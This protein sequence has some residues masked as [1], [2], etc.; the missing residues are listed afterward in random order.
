MVEESDRAEQLE[1]YGARQRPHTLIFL[2]FH[3]PVFLSLLLPLF[4]TDLCCSYAPYL[5]SSVFQHILSTIHI[6][7]CIFVGFLPSLFPL[8]EACCCSVSDGG[9]NE[10]GW[11]CCSLVCYDRLSHWFV[12]VVHWWRRPFAAEDEEGE[13]KQWRKMEECIWLQRIRG[14]DIKMEGKDER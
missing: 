10:Q 3:Y 13:T 14:E 4:Q 1:R 8:S 7:H 6:S 12:K 11:G 9:G 5:H 2:T